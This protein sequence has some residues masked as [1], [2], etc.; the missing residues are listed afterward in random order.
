MPLEKRLEIAQPNAL[1]PT[2]TNDP[3][4]V[5]VLPNPEGRASDFADLTDLSERKQLILGWTY[6]PVSWQGVFG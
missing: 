4:S 6:C 3:Q 1:N 5:V 2:D